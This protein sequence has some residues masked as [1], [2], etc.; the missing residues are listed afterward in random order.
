MSSTLRFIQKK[1]KKPIGSQI[2][3]LQD[4]C[5]IW[6]PTGEEGNKILEYSLE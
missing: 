3:L 4:G 5:A 6:V 1:K 2:G